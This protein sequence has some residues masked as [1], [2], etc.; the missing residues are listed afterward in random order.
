V[1]VDVMLF[2]WVLQV[3]Q[4]RNVKALDSWM[5][6]RVKRRVT[7]DKCMIGDEIRK[8]PVMIEQLR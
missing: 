2:G 5:K 3:L 1:F 6:I 8:R 7:I 4:T